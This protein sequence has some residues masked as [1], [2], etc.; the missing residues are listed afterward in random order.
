MDQQSISVLINLK[1]NKPKGFSGKRYFLV[2]N[3]WLYKVE[4][5]FNLMQVLN[6]NVVLTDASRI[7]FSTTL[8][9]GTVAIW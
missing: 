9:T 5:Y 8:L 4:Q 7:S 6:A 3:L 2:V 1:R